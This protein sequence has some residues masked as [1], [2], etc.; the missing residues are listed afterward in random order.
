M[1][2]IVSCDRVLNFFRVHQTQD[3][4]QAV[5]FRADM[6]IDSTEGGEEIRELRITPSH[7]ETCIGYYINTGLRRALSVPSF[8]TGSIYYDNNK[9]EENT[10]FTSNRWKVISPSFHPVQSNSHLKK[11]VQRWQFTL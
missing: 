1:Q 4:N 5:S 3:M 11:I 9:I 10:S 6:R 8:I 7:S 2:K